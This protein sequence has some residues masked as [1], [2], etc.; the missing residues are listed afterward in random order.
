[1]VRAF[2]G[3]EIL[4][5]EA[6]WPSQGRMRD[7]ALPSRINQARFFSELLTLSR[8]EGF[9]VNLFEAYD[10]PWKRQWE[11]TIGAHWG[12]LDGI[13]RQ[14]KYAEGAA[15]SNFP[16]WRLQMGAGLALSVAAFAAALLTRG[17]W[18]SG[19]TPWLAVATCA[20]SGGLL[21]GLAAEKALDESYGFDGWLFQALLVAAG[22]VLPLLCGHSVMTGRPLPVFADLF[23][24]RDGRARSWPVLISGWILTVAILAAT[25]TALGLVFDPR[26]RDFPFA[27]VTMCVVPIWI[28]TLVNPRKSGT[29]RVAEG[30]FGCL[31][32]SSAL[33]IAFNEGVRNWQ[34]LWTSA[35]FFL[36]GISLTPPRA[37]LV[38]STIADSILVRLFGKE[39][40]EVQG[41]AVESH[42]PPA[43]Q[44]GAAAGFVAASSRMERDK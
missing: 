31:F 35:A 29:S 12:L 44:A 32:L 6:G 37:L 36:L 5:G 8:Q 42:L 27:S 16:S 11:G 38:V 33:F 13:S 15:V 30:V 23:G 40:R 1:M 34:S 9:R 17:A 41:V 2:P 24:P 21:A 28:V 43:S 4:I 10:E 18:R 39:P 19:F 20:T 25:E 22:V 26:S 14:L 7:H 3:K